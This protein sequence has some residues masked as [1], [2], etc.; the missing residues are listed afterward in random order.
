MSVGFSWPTARHRKP[1]SS[2]SSRFW[3]TLCMTILHLRKKHYSP[4]KT[5]FLQ[6]Y[7]A[8]NTLKSRTIH[9][10]QHTPY[11]TQQRTIHTAVAPCHCSTRTPA[12]LLE[13][14]KPT[15]ASPNAAP[16][17]RLSPLSRAPAGSRTPPSAPPPTAMEASYPV[18]ADHTLACG[19]KQAE[20]AA[21]AFHRIPARLHCKYF[22]SSLFCLSLSTLRSERTVASSANTCLPP[23]QLRPDQ[24]LHEWR[25]WHVSEPSE[26]V[27]AWVSEYAPGFFW[28]GVVRRPPKTLLHVPIVV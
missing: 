10:Q 5:F 12:N 20:S 4:K 9:T 2:T 16:G 8:S 17:K 25:R 21:T 23:M 19:Q 3:H 24:K 11:I 1:G 15:V 14:A 22:Y 27:V 13:D 18:A 6:R 28:K 26:L 7:I